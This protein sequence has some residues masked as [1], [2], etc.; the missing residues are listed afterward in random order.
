MIVF[1][2]LAFL[3]LRF[4][5][6]LAIAVILALV[7][8][9]KRIYTAALACVGIIIY[10]FFGDMI[11]NLTMLTIDRY[12]SVDYMDSARKALYH[13]GFTIGLHD[14]PLGEG[15]GRFGSWIARVDYSPVYY[16]YGLQSVYGLSPDDPKWATDTYWP[17]IIGE[18][19]ILGTILFISFFL[20]V[21]R[22]IYV[23]LHDAR[24]SKNGKVFLLFSL[25][26]MI[27]SL[28]ESLGEQIF[29]GS[30]QYIFIFAVMGIAASQVEQGDHVLSSQA[31]VQLYAKRK[32]SYDSSTV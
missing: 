7:A 14:F 1:F 9:K 17:S 10:L 25:F 11:N 15:F 29:N 23:K 32:Y 16:E 19:G 3:S 12:I 30:P 18:V 27:Q 20:Y 24:V 28:V 21:M 4:K 6:L 8:M 22:G 26:I 13:T 31:S 5:V 2:I